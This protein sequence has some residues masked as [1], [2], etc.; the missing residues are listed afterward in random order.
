MKNI[1]VTRFELHDAPKNSPTVSNQPNS[2]RELVSGKQPA[3]SQQSIQ[4]NCEKNCLFL[5]EYPKPVS[6]MFGIDGS[7]LFSKNGRFPMSANPT[8]T[9]F[10][11]APHLPLPTLAKRPALSLSKGPPSPPPGNGTFWGKLRLLFTPLKTSARPDA[12]YRA[13]LIP[14]TQSSSLRPCQSGFI[15]PPLCR[16]RLRCSYWSSQ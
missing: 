15:F 1:G 9:Q 5:L 14:L 11:P 2:D 10:S 12:S 6:I 8:S 7:A 16:A 3:T 4:S 13:S